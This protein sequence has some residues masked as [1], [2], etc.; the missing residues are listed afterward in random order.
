VLAYPTPQPAITTT[1]F[2]TLN[3]RCM[4]SGLRARVAISY[5]IGHQDVTVFRRLQR[6]PQ[7]LP[8]RPGDVTVVA[9]YTAE[10]C[11]LLQGEKTSSNLLAATA[12]KV[13]KREVF[14]GDIF[15]LVMPN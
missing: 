2:I 10:P 5:T 6:H 14:D 11:T 8:P 13:P 7:A 12:L 1:D 15:A 9:I 3:E 4:V